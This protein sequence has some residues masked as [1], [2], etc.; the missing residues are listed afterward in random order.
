MT[1]RTLT[2]Q[3]GERMV[4]IKR[5]PE[6]DEYVV[7]LTINGKRRE[8]CDYYTCDW[9]DAMNTANSMVRGE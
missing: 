8:G 3:I 7:Q 4:R 5:L 2:M 1:T 6:F 9:E